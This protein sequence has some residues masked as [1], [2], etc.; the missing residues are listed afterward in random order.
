MCNNGA[1]RLVNG[2][3]VSGRVEIC[4]NNAYG[5]V[6]RDRWDDNDA[7]VVCRQLFLGKNKYTMIQKNI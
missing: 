1:I 2:T 7:T 4:L 6:C 5:T 3:N